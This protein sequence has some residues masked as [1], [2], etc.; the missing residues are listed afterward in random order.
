MTKRTFIC[1]DCGEELH[2]SSLSR[3]SVLQAKA[4][5]KVEAIARLADPVCT[6]C[7]NQDNGALNAWAGPSY[8][9]ND[10]ERFEFSGSRMDPGKLAAYLLNY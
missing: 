1:S 7:A 3:S 10:R 5:T 9:R 4:N 2:L 6:M 8:A